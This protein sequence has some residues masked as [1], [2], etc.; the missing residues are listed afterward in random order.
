MGLFNILEAN[1]VCPRCGVRTEMECEFKFGNLNLDRY[2]LNTRIHNARNEDAAMVNAETFSGEG[3][4]E[5]PGCS[6]D[7]WVVITLHEGRFQRVEVDGSRDGYIP[8]K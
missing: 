8:D 2:R 7:F 5:C 6:R 3:Y 1:L 4:A